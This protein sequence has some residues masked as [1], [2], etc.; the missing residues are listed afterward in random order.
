MHLGTYIFQP[1]ELFPLV[2]SSR[3]KKTSSFESFESFSSPRTQHTLSLMC[4]LGAC[5]C[6][7]CGWFSSSVLRLWT[8]SSLAVSQ[9]CLNGIF[10]Q[11]VFKKQKP[12]P[13]EIQWCRKS[14]TTDALAMWWTHKNQQQTD[15][16]TIQPE[17]REQINYT[18]SNFEHSNGQSISL[19]P[20]VEFIR[21]HLILPVGHRWY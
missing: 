8:L 10:R 3:G 16:R 13:T 17:L 20:I 12:A 11:I 9:T 19:C 1:D 5:V 15:L 4:I 6:F 2:F 21:I 14:I 18:W 7:C